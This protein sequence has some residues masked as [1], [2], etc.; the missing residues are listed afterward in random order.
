MK[1]TDLEKLKGL[2]LKPQPGA[3][4]GALPNCAA[5]PAAPAWGFRRRPLSFSSSVF[6]IRAIP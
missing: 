2:R 4:G 6:F 3:A 1:K 5:P